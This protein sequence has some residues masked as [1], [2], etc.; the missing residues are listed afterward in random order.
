MA[1][2]L[3]SSI[4]HGGFGAGGSRFLFRQRDAFHQLPCL[5]RDAIANCLRV[6]MAVSV[7]TVWM[8][9]GMNSIALDAA[10]ATAG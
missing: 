8:L 6:G 7:L 1:N 4:R 9:S 10:G 2:G 3:L 5:P